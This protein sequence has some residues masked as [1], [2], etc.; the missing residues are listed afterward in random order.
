MKSFKKTGYALFVVLCL[1]ALVLFKTHVGFGV[2]DIVKAAQAENQEDHDHDEDSDHDG[3]DEDEADVHNEEEYADDHDGH[4]HDEDADEADGHEDDADA[5][6][7]GDEAL[8]FDTDTM[9]EYGIEMAIAGKGI[10]RIYA[11]FPG[12]VVLNPERVSHIVPYVSGVVRTINK[13]LGDNVKKGEVMA[14]IESH[15][16][17]EIQSSFL[18]AKERVTLAETTYGREEKLWKQNISSETEYLDAKQ[19]LAELK[20]ELEVAKQKLLS[21]GFDAGYLSELSFQDNISLKM[22][23][24]MAPFDG[25][26]IEKHI[27]IG[28]AVADDSDAFRI[29]DLS[30]VWVNLTIYQKDLGSVHT[31]QS[32]VI[33]AR[34]QRLATSEIISYISPII[35]TATRTVTGRVEMKNTDLSWRPGLFV[36]GNIKTDEAE[37]SVLIPRTALFMMDNET[38]VFIRAGEDFESRP[39]T[40]G[41]ANETDVEVLSGIYHG[42]NYVAKGGFEIKAEL[43]T[44]GMDSHAGH[45]H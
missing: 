24:I 27:S 39:V 14:V 12:E 10:L 30:T 19:Q 42:D 37:V 26:I 35:D 36:M 9:E 2:S 31:G 41:R 17:S 5:D 6:A 43:V 34:E 3:H 22:Y 25:V 33:T 4:D 13:K 28:E 40:I 15:E 18:V 16:L 11:E 7:H 29:A 23:E 8:L 1:A 21:L 20:I 32:V 45:G 38:V 44:A